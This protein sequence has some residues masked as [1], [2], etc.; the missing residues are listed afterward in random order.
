MHVWIALGGTGDAW[1][2][3]PSL[4]FG[5]L[6]VP[7]VARLG[8]RWFGPGAGIAAGLLV[9]LSPQLVYLSQE[10]RAYSL[11]LLLGALSV[12]LMT[13]SLRDPGWRAAL[14]YVAV[15]VLMLHVHY[16]GVFVLLFEVVVAARAW[17]DDRPAGRRLALQQL[18][19]VAACLPWLA[20]AFI[21]RAPAQQPW[22]QAPD[23]IAVLRALQAL[24][25]WRTF[26][27]LP[28]L[29]G[30]VLR[31]GIVLF[32]VVTLAARLRAG[33][34]RTRGAAILSAAWLAIPLA[35]M[36]VVSHAVRPVFTIRYATILAAPA[37][38]VL[39]QGVELAGRVG[40]GLALALLAAL[41]GVGLLA[42]HR[43]YTREQW[44][45]AAAWV[46]SLEEPGDVILELGYSPL[47]HYYDG[48]APLLS[49]VSP[50]GPPGG[51]AAFR[52]VPGARRLQE[53]RQSLGAT[54]ASA[55]VH[56]RHRL[57]VVTAMEGTAEPRLPEWLPALRH[58]ETR[59]F[60]RVRIDRYDRVR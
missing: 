19:V 55:A 35:A 56:D 15:T 21:G 36:L 59:L 7:V 47:H 23:A 52:E 11:L 34:R 28:P 40:G 30:H 3:V 60:H 22:L 45:E 32:V 43:W 25:F 54:A 57:W 4:L 48:A 44:R 41:Q 10:A 51:V 26:P 18:G 13:R 58:A 17:W 9:A 16:L 6:T 12:D 37:A 42:E 50:P 8:T 2:R 46:R 29:L 33:A 1:V 20:V 31:L 53:R 49:V 5:T 24:L 27:E 39:G 38:L 14:G